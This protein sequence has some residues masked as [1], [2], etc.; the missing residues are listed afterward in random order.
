MQQGVVLCPCDAN[1]VVV[2]AVFG[3]FV[4]ASSSWAGLGPTPRGL[5]M[6]CV[7]LGIGEN[8]DFKTISSL[9]RRLNSWAEKDGEKVEPVFPQTTRTTKIFGVQLINDSRRARGPSRFFGSN[10]KL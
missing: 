6:R 2:V 5:I 10:S 1:V 3:E 7:R 9:L 8:H 4:S